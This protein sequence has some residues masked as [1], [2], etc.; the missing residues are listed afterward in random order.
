MSDEFID[1]AMI[2]AFME[3]FGTQF[4]ANVRDGLKAPLP[5]I[6]TKLAAACDDVSS[7]GFYAARIRELTGAKP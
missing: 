2:E 4:G 5:L 6:G 3:A 1:D 7:G